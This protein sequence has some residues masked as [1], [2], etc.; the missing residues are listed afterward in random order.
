MDI[1]LKDMGIKV[2]SETY[3]SKNNG[4]NV[5]GTLVLDITKYGMSI[6]AGWRNSIMK[7]FAV[8]LCSGN[9]VTVCSNMMFKGDFI[10]F[11]K[12][13]SGINFEELIEM[14]RRSIT[15]V[16]EQGNKAIAWQRSLKEVQLT[17]KGFKQITYDAMNNG[18][19]A[20]NKFHEFNEAYA[21]E[22]NL[23]RKHNGTLYEFHGAITRMNRNLN[24]FTI[25]NRTRQLANLCDEYRKTA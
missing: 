20:P 22:A 11:R 7:N 21:I 4:R 13:T 25:D 5:L 15:Q 17:D 14:E 2:V 12:H 8:G 1:L 6:M 24:L 10:E 23:D 3:S 18:I 16:L 9:Y 19:L